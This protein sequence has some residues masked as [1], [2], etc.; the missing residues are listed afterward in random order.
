MRVHGWNELQVHEP[1]ILNI[2][3]KRLAFDRRI[4]AWHGSNET[5]K[6]LEDAKDRSVKVASQRSSLIADCAET[7]PF[8]FLSRRQRACI[9]EGIRKWPGVP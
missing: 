6:R 2:D 8:Q 1:A 5:S 7:Y 9:K 4:M 3:P